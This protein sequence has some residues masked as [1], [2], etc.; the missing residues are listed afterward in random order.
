MTSPPTT[1]SREPMPRLVERG[2]IQG[3]RAVAVLLVVLAH[4]GLPGLSGGYIG[5]DVFFVVSGYLI[6]A[7][8]LREATTTGRVSL[9]GFYA[10]RAR[11]ILPA[12]TV[13]LLATTLASTVGL[14]IVR[15]G[16]VVED[17]LW[18]TFFLANVQF[19]RIGTDYFAADRAPSPVQHFWSLSVEEQF[20]L[21]WPALVALVLVWAA[22]RKGAEGARH[23][24]GVLTVVVSFAALGS[25]A[26]ATYLST[27][28]PAAAYFSTPARAWE[29]AAGVLLALAGRSLHRL[30]GRLRAALAV[31]GLVAIVAAA[32]LFDEL[33]PIPG[34]A[35]LLPVLGTVAVL[36]AGAGGRAPVVGRLL[37]L[38]PMRWIGDLSYSLYLWHWPFLILGAAYADRQL[39]LGENAL[40]L[41]GA[42]LASLATYHLVENPMRRASALRRRP[43]L[44]LVLWPVA[45]GSVLVASLWSGSYTDRAE[46]ELAASA[47]RFR[48]GD[49]PPEERVARTGDRLHDEIAL[50][51]DMATVGGPI[52]RP[53]APE[54]TQVTRDLPLGDARC[55]AETDEA[56]HDLCAVGDVGSDHT[57]VLFGSSLANMWLPALE[58]LGEEHGFEVVPLIKFG[59][60]PA[61]VSIFD[62][63]TKGRHESCDDWREWALGEI[64]RIR[65]ETVVVGT[66]SN[67][68][69]LDKAGT[70]SLPRPVAAAALAAG[71]EDVTARILRS[72]DQV[73][74][75]GDIVYLHGSPVA[76]LLREGATMASCTNEVPPRTRWINE[77]LRRAADQEGAKYVDVLELTCADGRC[78]LVVDGTVV[79]RDRQHLTRTYVLKV[80]DELFARLALDLG[81]DV[82]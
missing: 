71:M 13:V 45:A 26:W 66:H 10:K 40:L 62:Q 55:V 65:P 20:Y 60:P 79:Y 2:D 56:R 25:L 27:T 49:V 32:T 70:G 63:R 77:R 59:C 47:D 78:P 36:A 1:S 54:L 33:T 7:L 52:P 24:I 76:C 37:E 48:I 61:T 38:R 50:S 53:L 34:P 73:R 18:S 74:L 31:S 22:G 11:R 21:V 69:V 64:D 42:L 35:A 82:V 51:V 15:A 81:Q 44:A 5:V 16:E 68:R 3:L 8:L 6:S 57:V 9:T 39:G 29:L 72:A 14:S 4:A 41:L 58:A 17:V 46:A 75:L 12:A 80:R 28:A 67:G 19:A 30:G 23:R 43:R